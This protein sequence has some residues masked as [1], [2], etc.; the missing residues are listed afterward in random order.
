[1]D[2]KGMLEKWFQKTI[3]ITVFFQNQLKALRK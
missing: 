3:K 1:M 2:N